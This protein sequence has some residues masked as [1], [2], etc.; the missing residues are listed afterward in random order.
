M[1]RIRWYGPTVALVLTVLAV[2]FIGPELVKNLTHAQVR[3]QTRFVQNELKSNPSLAELS[4]A[5]RKVATVVEP[6][7]VAI[8][9]SSREPQRQMRMMPEEFRRFFGPRFQPD[10]PMPE[11]EDDLGEPNAPNEWEKYNV[12]RPYGSGS[13]WVYDEEGHIVT[14]NHVVRGAESITVRFSDGSERTAKL[15]AADP[16]TDVAVLKVEGGRL[17]PAALAEEPVEQGDIVFAFG[18]PF[19]FEFSMSQGIVSAKGRHLG[20]IEGGGYENFIQ[21]DAAINPG[22]SGGPL[23]N[24]YG[25]VIGMNTAIASQTGANNGLGFAIPVDMLDTVVQQIIKTGKVIRGYLGVYIQDLDLELA[26]SYGLDRRGVLVTQPIPGSPGEQAGLKEDDIIV[27]VDGKSVESADELRNRIA[28]YAPG[29][30]VPL[31]FYRDGK[32][33]TVTVTVGELPAQVAAMEE[34]GGPERMTPATPD[35]QSMQALRQLGIEGVQALTPQIAQRLKVESGVVITSVRP[36]SVADSKMLRR[37]MVITKVMNTEIKTPED[38]NNAL[39][40]AD[41]KKGVRVTVSEQGNSRVVL[42]KLP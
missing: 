2:M 1:S 3:A 26:R 12:P 41:L 29:K 14:N 33:Q 8:Q 10:G 21:T 6:S 19:R 20:I 35:E 15:V 38:L 4:S 24:I 23:T 17:H 27:E 30:K 31:K 16:K 32:E 18:S 36:N 25:Q 40:K 37:G 9:V 28:N 34:E 5:F 42:L 22:N 39:A 13:G 7:V 11:G